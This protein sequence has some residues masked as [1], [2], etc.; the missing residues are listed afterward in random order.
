LADS[1]KD[2]TDYST[3]IADPFRC[4][5]LLNENPFW[6]GNVTFTATFDGSFDYAGR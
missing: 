2:H 3:D 4:T 6:G 1:G 5:A